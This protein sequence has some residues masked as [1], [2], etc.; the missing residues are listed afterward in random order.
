MSAYSLLIKRLPCLACEVEGNPQP[1]ATEAHHQN[2]GGHA[3]QKRLGDAFQVPLCGWHHRA[4]RPY[5]MSTDAMT[6]LY[7][8]SLALDSRQFRFA[9]G[10]DPAQLAATNFKVAQL[11]PE[12]A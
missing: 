1:S 7:G 12:V 4:E 8:P 5:G 6:H 2:A 11:D 9:Y 3:G 10:D